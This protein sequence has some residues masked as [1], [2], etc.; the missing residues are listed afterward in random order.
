MGISKTSSRPIEKLYI[1]IR[2]K[3]T[4]HYILASKLLFELFKNSI[5]IYAIENILIE[6]QIIG[7]FQKTWMSVFH[8]EAN[9]MNLIKYTKIFMNVLTVFI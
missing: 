3:Q 5:C 8:Q 4:V 1:N 6:M 2:V 7:S 9:R